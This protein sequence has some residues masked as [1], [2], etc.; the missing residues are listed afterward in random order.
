MMALNTGFAP[1]SRFSCYGSYLSLEN[2]ISKVPLF[3]SVPSFRS[4]FFPFW[5]VALLVLRRC[6]MRFF[7]VFP[8]T[9]SIFLS[10]I[11]RVWTAFYPAYLSL[12]RLV[13]R[14]LV[15]FKIE[16][17]GLLFSPFGVSLNFESLSEEVILPPID[18]L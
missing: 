16:R 6:P 9:F 18:Y 3:Y 4:S 17:R 15:R 1:P 13:V 7:K 2:E 11:P 14:Y 5:L 12:P 8:L 10:W